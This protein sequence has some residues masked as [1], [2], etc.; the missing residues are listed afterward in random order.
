MK[1]VSPSKT[2][3]FSSNGGSI[4]INHLFV[5]TH[6]D[7]LMTRVG[8]AKPGARCPVGLRAHEPIAG[9]RG[10]PVPVTATR[11]G[12]RNRGRRPAGACRFAAAMV[13]PRSAVD[14]GLAGALCKKRQARAPTPSVLVTEPAPARTNWVQLGLPITS[15]SSTTATNL[16]GV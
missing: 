10:G 4:W 12:G 1:I 15:M 13:W 5:C 8:C 2:T 16:G 6:L 7:R 3:L 14:V 9:L 11:R